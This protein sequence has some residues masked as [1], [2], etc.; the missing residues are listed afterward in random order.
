MK[1]VYAISFIACLVLA[2]SVQ[3]KKARRVALAYVTSWSR[4]MPDPMSVTHICY[5][6]G[7]VNDTFNGVGISNPERLRAI[8]ALKSQNPDLKVLLSVGGWGSGRFSEMAADRSLRKTF[9]VECAKI[10]ADYN[11][12]GIDIDWEYP[13]SGMAN[14]SS[15]PA[16]KGNFTLLMHDLRYALGADALL[17]LATAASANFYDF[18]SFVDDVD[19]VS[20]MSYDMGGAPDH[21]AALYNSERFQGLCCDKA[22]KAHLEA[23]VPAEKL[24]L[25]LPFYGRGTHE[26]GNFTNFKDIPRHIQFTRNWDKDACVPYLTNDKGEVVLGYD[27][28]RSIKIKCK[29]AKQKGL[30]GVMYWDYDGDDAQG[31]LRTTVIKAMK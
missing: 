21:H 25:G 15:L 18:P 1:K 20:I 6:F 12:D 9:A 27:D 11:L 10:V 14:I 24:V 4:T 7:S 28:A 19:F 3:A 13:G 29:Y 16:D 23:G 31:T 8:A 5:A 26:I 2:C 17:T 30:R 22:L